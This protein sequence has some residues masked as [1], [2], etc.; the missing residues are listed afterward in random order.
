MHRV[1]EW[2]IREWA[3]KKDGSSSE[4]L[5][6][7]KDILAK[8]STICESLD[9]RKIQLF[10]KMFLYRLRDFHGDLKQDHI[11]KLKNISE[12]MCRIGSRITL[13]KAPHPQRDHEPVNGEEDSLHP[14]KRLQEE[15]LEIEREMKQFRRML[16][17]DVLKNSEVIICL[18]LHQPL[19]TYPLPLEWLACCEHEWLNGESEDP[20]W[21]EVRS[22]IARWVP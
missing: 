3:K 4:T 5:E 9:V 1:T 20:R 11:E 7:F 12:K 21:E 14:M 8:R 22:S 13:Y 15:T 16:S 18:S 6:Y 17:R 2:M 10:L 19:Q